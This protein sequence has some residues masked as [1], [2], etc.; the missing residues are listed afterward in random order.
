[1]YVKCLLSVLLTL[2]SYAAQTRIING[3]IIADDND[4]WHF[5][6]S[7]EYNGSL[8]C[9]GSLIAP[10]W[11]LSA[12]HCWQE[13]LTQYD[14]IAVGS[15]NLTRQQALG[16]KRV[17]VHP[18]YAGDNND[19][20]LFELETPVHDIA[21]VLLDRS[22]A[23]DAGLESWVAGWGT[24]VAGE[25]V[26]P[27]RLREARTP[28][29]DFRDCNRSYAE[30][31]DN[32]ICAG[33]MEGGMDSCQ[34]DSGGPLISPYHDQWVQ[35]GIVSWGVGCAVTG[36]PGIYTKVQNYIAWIESYTGALPRPVDT[37]TLQLPESPAMLFYLLDGS[38]P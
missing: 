37:T 30:L 10:T 17:I 35:T 23:L 38:T 15:Y 3:S 14:K 19:I 9:G 24:M 8:S 32:M 33:Y 21:P 12:A 28:I 18:D 4:K 16:I 13:P 5:I 2:S 11:V 34:G 22:S 29:V 36:Y 1:M 27:T 31:T 6:V 25:E 20:A 7:Y 26:F